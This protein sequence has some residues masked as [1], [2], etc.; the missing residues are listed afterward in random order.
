MLEAIFSWNT[1]WWILVPVYVAACAGLIVVV[2][3]QKGKGAGF[4]GAFGI[5]PGSEAVFGP[6]GSKSLPVRMTYIM[7]GVFLSLA[8]ILS[9]VGGH[10]TKGIAPE[11]EDLEATMTVPSSLDDLGTGIV[12]EDGE[13]KIFEDEPPAEGAEGVAAANAEAP[14]AAEADD[15]ET[16]QGAEPEAAEDNS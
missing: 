5:G 4:A 3:L 7:A 16:G 14:T 2:L 1:L 10:L 11:K 15:A 12:D 8:F 6:R 9:L 13:A